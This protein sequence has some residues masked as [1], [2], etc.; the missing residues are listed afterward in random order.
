VKKA[1]FDFQPLLTALESGDDAAVRVQAKHALTNGAI[2]TATSVN[3]AI[4]L[5]IWRQAR[6]KGKE[7]RD[8]WPGTPLLIKHLRTSADQGGAWAMAWLGLE[9]FLSWTAP[10]NDASTPSLTDEE[11]E[12][13][14]RRAAAKGHRRAA[15]RLGLTLKDNQEALSFLSQAFAGGDLD[16]E[17]PGEEGQWP[18]WRR[19]DNYP[20]TWDHLCDA[21]L[22]QAHRSTAL[23]LPDDAHE[24]FTRAAFSRDWQSSE[25]FQTRSGARRFFALWCEQEGRTAEAQAIWQLLIDESAHDS[26]KDSRYM[27]SEHKN[28]RNDWQF[29][30]GRES[31][32][33]AA[34]QAAWDDQT[35]GSNW[36][37]EQLA[38]LLC[39]N[40]FWLPEDEPILKTYLRST[41]AT[42]SFIAQLRFHMLGEVGNVSDSRTYSP[43]ADRSAAM[44]VLWWLVRDFQSS[45]L[46]LA[47]LHDA[48]ASFR[49]SL[50]SLASAPPTDFG[51]GD[52]GPSGAENVLRDTNQ[53]PSPSDIVRRE[54][55]DDVGWVPHT[56]S[57]ASSSYRRGWTNWLKLEGTHKFLEGPHNPVP[58]LRGTTL[59][60]ALRL[61]G[62]KWLP[63]FLDEVAF[64]IE[65]LLHHV[66]LALRQREVTSRQAVLSNAELLPIHHEAT[67]AKEQSV[68]AHVEEI[69]QDCLRVQAKN[70]EELIVKIVSAATSR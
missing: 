49:A 25:S 22:E 18:S 2:P 70:F 57:S 64:E 17:P 44:A 67:S 1:E 30:H 15:L 42:E 6:D 14:L 13:Q 43:E 45:W 28:Y 63:S 54:L 11:R 55:L 60:V 38:V 68:E 52:L 21:A 46:E 12:M 47:G 39:D 7:F 20:I 66:E 51:G 23:G 48:A 62:T 40:Y 34:L 10:Q 56:A 8:G 26:L 19:A 4:A 36:R 61:S 59:G 69:L 24:W 35:I 16:P 29:A 53:L 37:A 32:R 65:G 33:R 50:D 5:A 27:R 9:P 31:A 41:D 58:P 3:E